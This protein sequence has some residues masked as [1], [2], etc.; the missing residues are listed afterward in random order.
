M[1][2][3]F[4]DDCEHIEKRDYFYDYE[5]RENFDYDYVERRKKE[6]NRRDD[7]NFSAPI[8]NFFKI[9]KSGDDVNTL[10]I[11]GKSHSVDAFVSFDEQNGIITFVKDNGAVFI[12]GS[13][14]IDAIIIDN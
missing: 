14:R 4:Y 5:N 2:G 6:S 8:C 12:V 3:Y 11:S 13:D 10:I 1:G 9:L 7:Y